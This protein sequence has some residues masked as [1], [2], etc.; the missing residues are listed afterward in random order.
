MQIAGV[1]MTAPQHVDG[2]GLSCW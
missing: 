2:C 1:G